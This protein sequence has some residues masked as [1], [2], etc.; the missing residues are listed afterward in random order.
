MTADE[1]VVPDVLCM[2]EKASNQNQRD[3][4][5]AAS[6]RLAQ[7]SFSP[8]GARVA[9]IVEVTIMTIRDG[10]VSPLMMLALNVKG[11]RSMIWRVLIGASF[12]AIVSVK[13]DTVFFL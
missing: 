7:F 10:S 12:S 13:P 2:S 8:T 3:A 6:S 1:V 4:C 9:S 11:G 5:R